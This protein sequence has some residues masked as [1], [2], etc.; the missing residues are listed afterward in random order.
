MSA[1]V[2][3]AGGAD[4][5]ASPRMEHLDLRRAPPLR[6]SSLL[7]VLAVLLGLVVAGALAVQTWLQ[8]RKDA[9]AVFDAGPLGGLYSVQL[10]NGQIYYGKLMEVQAGYVRLGEVYYI[11]SFTQPNGQAGNRVVN[12]QKNDWHGPLWQSIPVDKIVFME[13]V[14]PQSQLAKL[15]QQE[16]GSA[17][18]Q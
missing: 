15:I 18:A 9:G 13:A 14:G 17:A 7:P 2:D 3:M 11:Q 16:K 4:K 10:L 8:W 6:G 5:T 12:R 1:A